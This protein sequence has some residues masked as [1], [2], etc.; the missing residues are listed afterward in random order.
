MQFYIF[1]IPDF[2]RALKVCGYSVPI[3]PFKL[4]TQGMV[5]HETFQ[6]EKKKWVEPDNVIKKKDRFFLVW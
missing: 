1:C 3:E 2:C 4:L 6:T 5:C